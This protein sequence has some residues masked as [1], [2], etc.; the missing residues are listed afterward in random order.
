MKKLLLALLLPTILL[1][2]NRL[3]DKPEATSI[4]SD[5][6]IYFDGTTNG[7]RKFDPHKYALLA[8]NNLYSGINGYAS[9]S[10]TVFSALSGS[11]PITID[12]TKPGSAYTGNGTVTFSYSGTPSNDVSGFL[13]SF[14]ASGGTLTP[15]FPTTFSIGQNTN[16]TGIGT[17]ASG[18]TV[19]LNIRYARARWECWAGD[20]AATTGTGSYVLA[21]SPTI[22]T[23]VLS[24]GASVGGTARAGQMLSLV[25]SKT[26]SSGL[27]AGIA[28]STTL[29]AGANGDELDGIAVFQQPALI[30]TGTYT[31]LTVEGMHIYAP[32]GTQGSGTINQYVG[33]FIDA[34]GFATNVLGLEVSDPVLFATTLTVNQKIVIGTGYSAPAWTTA[35]A[36]L[37]LP[38]HTFTDTTSSGTVAEQAINSFIGAP[39]IAASSNTTYTD[40]YSTLFGGAPNASTHVTQ[41]RPHSV[42]IKDSTQSN[43]PLT[44]AFVV[45]STPGT[46]S[47][48]VS[49]GNGNISLGGTIAMNSLSISGT[50]GGSLYTNSGPLA[51]H[52]SAGVYMADTS[53]T[54][55]ASG[56][57]RSQINGL[58]DK[59]MDFYDSTQSYYTSIHCGAAP[60]GAGGTGAGTSPTITLAGTDTSGTVQVLTGTSPAG[61]NATIV[62]VTFNVAYTSAPHGVVIYPANSATAAL[63]GATVAYPS[64]W[65]TTTFVIASGTSAL[66]AAT[67]YKWVY[68][69]L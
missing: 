7:V 35:G 62:T 8:G 61:S 32:A 24:G 12:T 30:N 23:P 19:I 65:G 21:N 47:T 68:H 13:V 54:F 52:G 56:G 40:S 59:V 37:S 66:T 26:A 50:G 42:G 4:A 51:L 18:Q 44:G 11:G 1:G 29:A 69:V 34:G 10:Y 5:D 14:T 39:T 60:T 33:L 16:I 67:T 43:D 55:T 38:S 22:M 48:A 53:V 17:I 41:T 64:S 6:W 25:G 49:I 31:G 36:S 27:A 3:K 2:Q 58:T 57:T 20:P 9:I 15:V 63:S 46:A 45:Y 28:I